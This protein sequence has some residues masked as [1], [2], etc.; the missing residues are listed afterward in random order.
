MKIKIN[1]MTTILWEDREFYGIRYMKMWLS[2]YLSHSAT[3]GPITD[4]LG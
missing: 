2:L 4:F 1:P 3:N